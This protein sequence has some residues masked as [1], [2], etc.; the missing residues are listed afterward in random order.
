[1]DNSRE[2]GARADNFEEMET[3]AGGGKREAS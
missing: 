2:G 3:G 1:M